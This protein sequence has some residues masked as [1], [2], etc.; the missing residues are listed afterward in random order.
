MAGASLTATHGLGRLA[1]YRILRNPKAV[2]AAVEF[3]S[4]A[5]ATAAPLPDSTVAAQTDR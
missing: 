4:Q 3:A 1:H 2:R 5:T